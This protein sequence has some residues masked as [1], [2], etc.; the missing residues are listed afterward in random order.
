MLKGRRVH[1]V[2]RRSGRGQVLSS[3]SFPHQLR[4]LPWIEP[5]LPVF[6]HRPR[7]TV[8]PQLRQQLTRTIG[9]KKLLTDMAVA[10]IVKPFILLLAT[11]PGYAPDGRPLL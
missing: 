1:A 9:V 4:P 6:T 2:V 7:V 5:S 3:A 8:L 10:P 11:G